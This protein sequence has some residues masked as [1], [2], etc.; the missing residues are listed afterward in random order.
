MTAVPTGKWQ[1]GEPDLDAGMATIWGPDGDLIAYVELTHHTNEP[2]E[3]CTENEVAE[4]IV[5]LHNV[6]GGGA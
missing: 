1:V 5:N 4:Y 2:G 3:F 6:L